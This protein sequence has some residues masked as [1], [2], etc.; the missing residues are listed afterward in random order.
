MS[1]AELKELIADNQTRKVIQILLDVVKKAADPELYNDVVLQSAKYQEYL[2]EKAAG[3]KSQEDL[4]IQK[5]KIDNALTYIVD[6]LPQ[7]G[8]LKKPIASRQS[9]ITLSVIIFAALALTLYFLFRHSPTSGSPSSPFEFT[10]SVLTSKLPDYPPLT[11]A[12]LQ[13][14]L[15]NRW[16]EAL[17]DANGDA[18]FKGIPPQFA[19]K[20]VPWRLKS[21]YW[22][23]LQ[24]TIIL[25]G[26]SATVEARPNGV[27]G[28]I[29]GT[30][31]SA[32][33]SEFLAG[34]EIRLENSQHVAL[35]DESG[36][37]ELS[38]PAELQRD[39]YSISVSKT[40][41]TTQN[42]FAHPLSGNLDIR[43]SP[44]R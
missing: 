3:T 40:G 9:L 11:G 14:K 1:P 23:Q 27:L 15:D 38:V 39:R 8:S 41:F 16:D 22:E 33:G 43:L 20:P 21:E 31:R 7:G 25:E 10:I 4:D 35:S 30:V 34:A 42:Q 28:K 24:D 37:F 36:Y 26:K 6:R 29:A 19:G 2:R 5:A 13:I 18:D 32:D 12:S 17:V 44:N